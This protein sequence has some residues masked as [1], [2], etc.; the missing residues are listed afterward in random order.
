MSTTNR[1]EMQ[2]QRTFP[3]GAEEWHCPECQRALIM[4]HQ[5]EH[6]RL[7]IIVLTPGDELASHHGAVGGVELQGVQMHESEVV[8]VVAAAAN[9]TML[10]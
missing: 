9:G 8:A 1:H 2:L 7:K 10:H 6:G 3:S 5:P 4:H